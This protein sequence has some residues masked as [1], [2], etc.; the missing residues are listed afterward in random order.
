M[1]DKQDT[2]NECESCMKKLAP[3]CTDRGRA[4]WSET[5]VRQGHTP[6]DFRKPAT[7]PQRTV[8]RPPTH[9]PDGAADPPRDTLQ[10]PPPNAK[11]SSYMAEPSAY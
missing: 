3:G 5:T 2:Q 11:Q 9:G 10:T 6:L 4:S 8:A 7:D 1:R